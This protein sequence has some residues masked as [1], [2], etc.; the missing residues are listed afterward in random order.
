MTRETRRTFCVVIIQ[1]YVHSMRLLT[2]LLVK[3]AENNSVRAGPFHVLRGCALEQPIG[4]IV[5]V[6][7]IG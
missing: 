7:V 1:F 4:N 5:N 6:V 2:V 3:F